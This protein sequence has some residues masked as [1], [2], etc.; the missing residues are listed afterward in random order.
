MQ[1]RVSPVGGI[2]DNFYTVHV[3]LRP[4]GQQSCSAI[5]PTLPIPC[6]LPSEHR[7]AMV[8][9]KSG[10]DARRKQAGQA[11]LLRAWRCAMSP[12]GAACHAPRSLVLVSQ[13]WRVST[14]PSAASQPRH[15][16][17]LP[18]ATAE[19]CR[20][21]LTWIRWMRCLWENPTSSA[22]TWAFMHGFLRIA[23]AHPS[24]S[25]LPQD[26][27]PMLGRVT[28]PPLR[29]VGLRLFSSA[30]SAALN[31]VVAL[32]LALGLKPAPQVE[33]D[34]DEN[35]D[36]EEREAHQGAGGSGI[37]RGLSCLWDVGATNG[38]EPCAGRAARPGPGHPRGHCQGFDSSVRQPDEHFPQPTF[39]PPPPGTPRPGILLGPTQAG[40]HLAIPAAGALAGQVPGSSRSLP[41][42]ELPP[43]HLADPAAG[44][45]HG[46]HPQGG[47]RALGCRGQGKCEERRGR[48]LP[49][50]YSAG[51]G[52]WPHT[53]R[54]APDPGRTTPARQDGCG[55]GCL[56]GA[57][58]CQGM[59][60]FCITPGRH[61]G[62]SPVQQPES[63]TPHFKFSHLQRR[64][65][66]SNPSGA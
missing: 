6:A 65:L 11:A 14:R 19:H 17:Q 18:T 49:G 57:L 10:A 20:G 39:S 64:L 60:S 52:P 51:A 28:A 36:G 62:P 63:L 26:I 25:A 48:C 33:D 56:H 46:G 44:T 31:Q 40:P 21:L 30:E 22:G 54:G 1:G 32:M 34:E 45:G 16:Q 35:A 12:L 59:L 7:P 4:I 43:R 53:T 55:G 13:S 5:H 47:G 23:S 29:P 50:G 41:C 2:F 15:C 58:A 27:A 37:Q 42:P 8:W 9:P 38:W 61:F 3:A 66:P 24:P